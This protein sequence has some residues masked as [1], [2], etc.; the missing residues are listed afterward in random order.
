MK[1]DILLEVL[2]FDWNKGNRV[3]SL[4]KHNTSVKEQEETFLNKKNVVHEDTKHSKSEKRFLLFS[5]TKLREG[6]NHCVYD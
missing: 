1:P 3:K 6:F 2:E 4:I 5:R